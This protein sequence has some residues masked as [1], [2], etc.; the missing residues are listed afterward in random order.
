MEESRN[1]EFKDYYKILGVESSASEDDIRRAYRKLARKY[2]PDVSKEADTETR[3]REVNEAYDVLRDKEKRQAY[4]NLAAG[5]SPDGGFEPPPG[6]DQGFEFHYQPGEGDGDGRFSGFFSALFGGQ[7][8]NRARQENFRARGQ[9][10]HAAIEVDIDDALG[11]ATRE[12]SLRS[13][14]ADA[15][16][17]PQIHTR[18]LS[19]N[20]PAGVREGQFIRLTGQGMPGYGGGE[21]GDLYLEIRFRAHDRYRAEGRDLYMELPITPWEA[22]LGASIQIPTPGG[23][24]EVS[25]PAGSKSGRKLRLRGRGIPGNPPGDLYLV[26]ELALPPADTEAARQAY[27]TLAEQ[28]PFNPRRH[29]GV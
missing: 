21:A 22:A 12:I 19:V 23:Q 29:L 27:K 17:Q 6:W 11:G 18:T 25:V 3:M 14:Q 8:R 28:L 13:M 20:I 5:V 10:Q 7:Q 15:Q 4:D 26:L 16:G 1:M 2:H 9:D 24:L